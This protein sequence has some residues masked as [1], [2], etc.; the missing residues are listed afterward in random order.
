MGTRIEIRTQTINSLHPHGG[1]HIIE[2]I[3]MCAEQKGV[4]LR[5]IVTEAPSA[6]GEP[7]SSIRI[8]GKVP[9]GVTEV[10]PPKTSTK[11]FIGDAPYP[12]LTVRLVAKLPIPDETTTIF[13]KFVQ[14]VQQKLGEGHKQTPVP[15]PV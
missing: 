11:G 2:T 5:E 8:K 12:T 3:E 9:K 7:D 10:F 13:D 6:S 4:E 14:C 15:N 1:R